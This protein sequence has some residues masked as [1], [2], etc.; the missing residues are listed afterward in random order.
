MG[1]S[2]N[3]LLT[4]IKELASL[5]GCH[6]VA[7]SSFYTT[8]PIGPEDQNDFLNAVVKLSTTLDKFALLAETQNIEKLHQRVRD[9]HWGP[10]T[11]DLDIL[12]FGQQTITS[13]TLTIPHPLMHERGFVL[14]PLS[15]I[16]DSLDIADKGNVA[17]LLVTC[18]NQQVK[19]LDEMPYG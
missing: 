8:A 13:D 3:H 4:A 1:D 5:K 19:K 10:R 17:Q 11:L 15:D 9:R 12:L 2:K 16:D 14:H 18:A 6:L 7:T